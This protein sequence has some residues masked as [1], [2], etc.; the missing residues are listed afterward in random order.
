MCLRLVASGI[1]WD[2][3]ILVPSSSFSFGP[4]KTVFPRETES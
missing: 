2:F 3:A 1:T 4:T